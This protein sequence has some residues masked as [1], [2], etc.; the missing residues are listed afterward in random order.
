MASETEVKIRAAVTKALNTSA[1]FNR[2]LKNPFR[3]HM[4]LTG[5]HEPMDIPPDDANSIFSTFLGAEI[6]C[7]GK[8]LGLRKAK[9]LMV[10]MGV[11]MVLLLAVAAAAIVFA[12]ESEETVAATPAVTM[13]AERSE[14]CGPP[15]PCLN[16]G[17][18]HETGPGSRRCAC[19][20]G[21]VG[22]E[23]EINMATCLSSPCT[24]GATCV[25]DHQD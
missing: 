1:A 15:S 3:K 5:I 8:R 7:C 16:G 23:C 22:A 21:F 12:V 4:F 10:V 24:N 19:R 9:R 11:A 13:A 14:P 6:V 18:C 17:K 20:A 2:K 25:D